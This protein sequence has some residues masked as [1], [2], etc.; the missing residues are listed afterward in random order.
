MLVN[1]NLL[2]LG[3]PKLFPKFT[4]IYRELQN[5]CLTGALPQFGNLMLCPPGADALK[6]HKI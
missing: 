5:G 1:L 6:E 2:H 3:N 4:S